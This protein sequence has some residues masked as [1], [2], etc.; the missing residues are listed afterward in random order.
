VSLEAAAELLRVFLYGA[1]IIVSAYLAM[2]FWTMERRVL[3]FAFA[4]TALINLTMLAVLV[5]HMYGV[6]NEEIRFLL[7]P[8]LILQL[9][10]YVALGIRERRL[11]Q[12]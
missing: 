4:A 7:T 11:K 10:I 2:D 3:S 6:W 9:T 1:M 5:S 12:Q 8:V